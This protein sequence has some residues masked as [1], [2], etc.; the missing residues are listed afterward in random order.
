MKLEKDGVIRYAGGKK[1]IEKL[2]EMGYKEVKEKK[3]GAK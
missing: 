1:L 2:K 3:K